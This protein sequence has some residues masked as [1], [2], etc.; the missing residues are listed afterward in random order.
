MN[1]PANPLYIGKSEGCRAIHYF[2]ISAIKLWVLVQT[3]SVRWLLRRFERLLTINDLKRN[4]KGIKFFP[5][6]ILFGKMQCIWIDMFS[7]WGKRG[8][9]W[10]VHLFPYFCSKT[11][12]MGTRSNPHWGGSNVYQQSMVWLEIRKNKTKSS[13]HVKIPTEFLTPIFAENITCKISHWIYQTWGIR[14]N[15][16]QM[17]T[18]RSYSSQLWQIR[19]N[20]SHVKNPTEFLTHIFADNATCNLLDRLYQT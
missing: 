14:S 19:Q 7:L 16:S 3:A 2:L 17:W 8:V 15:T 10:G 4:K 12:I 18:I 9:C 5:L 13:S 20:L 6:K 11:Q 1:T